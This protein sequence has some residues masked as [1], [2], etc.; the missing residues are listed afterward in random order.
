MLFLALAR[1]GLLITYVMEIQHPD[2]EMEPKGPTRDP[3][4]K[5]VKVASRNGL[6]GSP[7]CPE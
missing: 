1:C 7:I 5:I 6:T 2:P 4:L 3:G